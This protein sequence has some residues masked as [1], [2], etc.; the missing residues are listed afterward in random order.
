MAVRLTP[1]L[2]AWVKENGGAAY[3]RGLVIVDREAKLGS[4]RTCSHCCKKIDPGSDQVEVQ[5][6]GEDASHFHL[7]CALPL[8]A[9]RTS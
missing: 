2:V 5:I 9:K 6:R 7:E 4:D 8:L 3:M 1:E